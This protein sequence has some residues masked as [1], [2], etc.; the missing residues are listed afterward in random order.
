M[1]LAW[2]TTP[3]IHAKIA[4]MENVLKETAEIVTIAT[5][6][7]TNAYQ[8]NAHFAQFAKMILA[9]TSTPA[10][11]VK[12][13]SME[14]VLKETVEIV[15]TATKNKT[16]AYQRN[17]HFAQFAKMILAWTSTPATLAKI[18]SMENVLKETAEIVTT[19]TKNK[20]NAY[21]RNAH[22]AQFAKMILAWTSTPVT[23][24]KIASM[25]NVLKETVEIVITATKNKTNAYQWNAHFAQFAKMILALTSIP[26]VLV[27]TV[28]AKSVLILTVGHVVLAIMKLLNVKPTRTNASQTVESQTV[29]HVLEYPER[30]CLNVNTFVRMMMKAAAVWMMTA[31]ITVRRVRF[32]C[33]LAKKMGKRRKIHVNV[34]MLDILLLTKSKSA[35]RNAMEVAIM[36]LGT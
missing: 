16:N 10:T 36:T 14:N 25:E 32:Q 2:T 29:R 4:S 11:L 27:N 13:A 33:A 34:W 22:F 7:K 17:A 9:W 21:Q 26:A 12:I 31:K 28:M 19:A 1:I 6:N 35:Q 23:L 20:T 3:A 18:A 30:I 5:K 24:A 15:I 8:W